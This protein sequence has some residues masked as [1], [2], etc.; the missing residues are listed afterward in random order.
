MRKESIGLRGL[1]NPG[2]EGIEMLLE[3]M[4]QNAGPDGGAEIIVGMPPPLLRESPYS[5]R[6]G[7]DEFGNR[8]DG[9]PTIVDLSIRGRL[10]REY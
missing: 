2:D 8:Y 4:F 5:F 1:L 7:F 6:F 3:E 9:L 10:T